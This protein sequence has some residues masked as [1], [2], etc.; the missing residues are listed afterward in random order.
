MAA[1]STGQGKK[2]QHLLKVTTFCTLCLRRCDTK[3]CAVWQTHTQRENQRTINQEYDP[4]FHLHFLTR[5]AAAIHPRNHQRIGV[6]VCVCVCM[7]MRVCVSVGTEVSE[8]TFGGPPAGKLSLQNTKA[9][10]T[11]I[12]VAARGGAR[13]C[14][15]ACVHFH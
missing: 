4:S 3:K 10:L 5:W 8:I 13:T 9:H 15:W 2:A 6:C 12:I 14:A 11:Q 7:C 1:G